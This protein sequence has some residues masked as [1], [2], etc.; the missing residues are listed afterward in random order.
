[1]P[2]LNAQNAQKSCICMMYTAQSEKIVC[3]VQSYSLLRL[4]EYEQMHS[5]CIG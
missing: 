3:L 2:I 5:M 4:C 1:M